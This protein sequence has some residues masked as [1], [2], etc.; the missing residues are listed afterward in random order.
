MF[1]GIFQTL[2][3]VVHLN[4]KL[5]TKQHPFK[6]VLYTVS[7]GLV[8]KMIDRCLQAYSKLWTVRRTFAL[9]T[10]DYACY[11]VSCHG[12]NHGN[13]KLSNNYLND[14]LFK[15]PPGRVRFIL[16]T[17]VDSC[18][19]LKFSSNVCLSQ[20]GSSSHEVNIAPPINK[21]TLRVVLSLSWVYYV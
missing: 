5:I 20:V 8:K 11:L 1:A 9:Q 13:F 2:V 12:D 3:S 19:I 7:F 6:L 18:L 10:Y 14:I 4:C 17:Y 21:L 15:I 16:N